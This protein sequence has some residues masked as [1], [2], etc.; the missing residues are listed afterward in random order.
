[1][2]IN[3]QS[4]VGNGGDVRVR[5]FVDHDF[6]PPARPQL[7][8]LATGLSPVARQA[9]GLALDFTLQPALVRPGDMLIL[10]P[11]LSIAENDLHNELQDLIRRA[12]L[13]VDTGAEVFAFG[14]RYPT[15]DG[16]HEIHMNQGN[17][18]SPAQFFKENGHW[19]DGAL[20]FR[21]PGAG[22]IPDTFVAVYIAFHTQDWNTLA[23]GDPD[24]DRPPIFAGL[25]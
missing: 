6:Q 3:V 20:V 14:S 9:G 4:Q 23:N 13:G 10:D 21:F 5:Y 19:Q 2:A 17:P 1:V 7:L 11:G 16:I 15:H 22:D 24:P 12:R 18:P 8:A 25:Q